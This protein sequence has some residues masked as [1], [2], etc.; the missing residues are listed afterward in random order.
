MLFGSKLELLESIVRSI[1]II[2]DTEVAK[3]KM[4]WFFYIKSSKHIVVD[5]SIFKDQTLSAISTSAVFY[6]NYIIK[7]L[8]NRDTGCF[9]KFS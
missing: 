8:R 7:M 2:M 1:I 5:V 9:M 4:H 3:D 6:I